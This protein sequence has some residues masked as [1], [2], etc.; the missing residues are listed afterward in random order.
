MAV[1]VVLLIFRFGVEGGEGSELGDDGLVEDF[2]LGQLV[3]VGLGDLPLGFGGVKDGGAV[4]G[5]EVGGP[6]NS[7]G[8]GRGRRR[9]KTFEERAERNDGGVVEDRDRT[10]N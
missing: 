8:W 3:D 10:I 5:S 4:L 9:S 2:G 7:V 1:D 6:G